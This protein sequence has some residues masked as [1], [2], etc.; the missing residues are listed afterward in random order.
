M[1][2]KGRWW[3]S[4]R[5]GFLLGMKSLFRIP[6]TVSSRSKSSSDRESTET[7]IITRITSQIYESADSG[8]PWRTPDDW[9]NLFYI[10]G[11][12][13]SRRTSQAIMSRMSWTRFLT[14]ADSI[15]KSR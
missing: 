12:G 5:E 14:L 2:K 10:L 8:L 9:D 7:A 15:I 4:E 1:S 3:G 6:S 13:Q 11:G